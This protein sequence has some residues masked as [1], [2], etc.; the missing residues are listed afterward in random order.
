MQSAGRMGNT[1]ATYEEV[2]AFLDQM[3]TWLSM[4][5][6]HVIYEKREKNDQFMASMDWYKIDTIKEWLLKLEPEDYYEGPDPNETPGLNP[7]W[8]FGK[9]I[10]GHLCFIKIYLI[11]VNN[12]YCI[13][14][15]FAEHDMALPLKNKTESI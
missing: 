10:E 12:V 3:K 8:K 14:F 9:R 1:T 5:G 11:P 4:L 13:S 7:V 6:G 2:K 15:H